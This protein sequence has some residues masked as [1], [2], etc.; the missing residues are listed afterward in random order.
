MQG[1]GPIKTQALR[2]LRERG[3][4]VAAVL[5]VGVLTQTPELRTAYP[6]VPHILFEPVAEFAET[7]HANYAGM[8]YR[9]VSAAVSDA[10][11]E[12]TLQTRTILASM[13]ISHSS[14]VE[15]AADTPDKRT[16]PMITLDGYLAREPAPGPYLLKIDVDG[17]E[18]AV[19][20]GAEQTLRQS[21]IVII[22]A[23]LHELAE[24]I[25]AVQRHG[26]RL[27]DLVE[28]CYY[29]GAFWQCDAV[30][31]RE[32]L[33]AGRFAD[34]LKDFQAP[35]YTMY[36]GDA[37]AETEYLRRTLSLTQMKLDAVIAEMRRRGVNIEF[38]DQ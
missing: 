15:G 37:G 30:L 20:R 4:P 36:H 29:D 13:T 38:R 5:D 12:T 21:S 31:V 16:V 8:D 7:I 6:D 2:L 34:L 3:V 17:F 27:F 1:R 33:M 18:L 26:F 10:E 24:R 14:I 23:P 25:A 35:L 22:E 32:D 9:L 19:L 28:P 11:G